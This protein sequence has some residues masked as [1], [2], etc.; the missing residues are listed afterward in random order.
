V[1]RPG[2]HPCG[3]ACKAAVQNR[4]GRFC[5]PWGAQNATGAAKTKKAQLLG[6]I[7]VTLADSSRGD[8]IRPSRGLTPAGPLVKQRSKI[9]PLMDEGSA[10][11]AGANTGLRAIL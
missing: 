6:A 7:L 11:Y 3:A 9:A 2:T 5:E 8:L 10:D 1:R 4:S